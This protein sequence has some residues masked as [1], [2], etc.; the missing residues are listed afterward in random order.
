MN[1][2]NN[3]NEEYLNALSSQRDDPIFLEIKKLVSE[4]KCIS[5]ILSSLV[6]EGI[7]EDAGQFHFEFYSGL[8][9]I[10]YKGKYG[11][12]ND[13]GDLIVPCWFEDVRDYHGDYAAVKYDGK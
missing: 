3:S 8:A 9:F 13:H 4:G 6:A 5:E 12:I 2:T 7:F 1:Q 10:C 11:F